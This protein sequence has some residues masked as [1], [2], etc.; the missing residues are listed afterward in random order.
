[1]RQYVENNRPR[2]SEQ[3]KAYRQYL[4][5]EAFTSARMEGCIPT[6]RIINLADKLV[7]GKISIEEFIK[8]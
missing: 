6:E 5:N 8:E 3:E 2:I 7:Q 1:M 4:V